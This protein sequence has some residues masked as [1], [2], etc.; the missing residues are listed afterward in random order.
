LKKKTDGVESGQSQ[1]SLPKHT[2]GKPTKEK[3]QK[4]RKTEDAKE[5]AD[6]QTY[7]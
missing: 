6:G 7:D 4:I 2:N 5:S 3:L 1:N